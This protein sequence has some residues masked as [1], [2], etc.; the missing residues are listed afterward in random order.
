MFLCPYVVKKHT[1]HKTIAF[2]KPAQ[3]YTVRMHG[4]RVGCVYKNT[5]FF[6]FFTT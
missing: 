3:T 1:S 5:V 4:I 6:Y 2:K